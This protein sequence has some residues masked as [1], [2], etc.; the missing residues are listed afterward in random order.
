MASAAADLIVIDT[1]RKLYA[2][3]HGLAGRC[4]MRR[5]SVAV[6]MPVPTA[7]RS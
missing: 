3:G 6:P 7:A 2:R 1:L 5:R 4:R